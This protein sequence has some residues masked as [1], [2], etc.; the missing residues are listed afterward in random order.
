MIN[1]GSR[2]ELRKWLGKQPQPVHAAI[3]LR[4]SLRS[5]PIIAT[6]ESNGS[7]NRELL[8]KA[9]RNLLT[10]AVHLIN[11]DEEISGIAR[12]IATPN[13][14]TLEPTAAIQQNIFKAI[15]STDWA[16]R[17][18]SN[19]S[20][21]TYGNAYFANEDTAD[22]IGS[23]DSF[24][25]SIAAR[26]MAYSDTKSAP[27]EMISLKLWDKFELAPILVQQWEHFHTNSKQPDHW[28]FWRDW[29]Q[30][31]LDGKPINWDLQREVAMIPDADWDKGPEHIAEK[32]AEIQADFL[33]KKAPLAETIEFNPKTAKFFATPIPVAKPDLLGTT[34][35]QVADALE[36]ALADQGNGLTTKSREVRVLTRTVSKY[37]NDPQRIE[38]DFTSVAV[39]LRRQLHDTNEL[40]NSEE[41]LALLGA[42]EEG[43]LGI[44]ATHPEVAANR[45]LLAAQA[46]RELSDHDKELLQEARPILEAISEGIMADDFAA[47]IPVLIND[48][49]LPLP[50]G[51]PRLPAMDPSMRVFGRVAK[52]SKLA[53]TEKIIQQID[54]SSGFKAAKILKLIKDVI[55]IGLH[56][57]GVLLP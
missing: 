56:L 49:M 16:I 53:N 55:E 12:S 15:L 39:G 37:G 46:M 31:F 47:D 24:D 44:R 36:D 32:I 18:T 51:A 41:N 2:E 19:I 11:L 34:L 3:G 4:V 1:M 7:I 6:S 33:V 22:A 14:F 17:C 42:V 23:F 8:L 21:E 43:A 9:A 52:I 45:E 13:N 28:S 27:K 54:G 40:P 26:S 50:M 38:M 10:S 30:G 48:A 35:S 20:G 29:Y 25:A 5:F 57:F